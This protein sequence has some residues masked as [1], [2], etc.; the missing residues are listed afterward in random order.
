ME[1]DRIMDII[2]A[3][4]TRKSIRGYLPDP[5]PQEI[6]RAIL[7]TAL[8]SPSAV[9]NQPWE[10]TIVTGEV[11]DKIRHENVESLL[12]GVPAYDRTSRYAGVFKQRRV[13]LAKD[14]FA[15]MDI[16]RDDEVKRKEWSHRG[17]RFFDAPVAIIIS[18]DKSLDGSWSLFDI[19]AISQTICLAAMH[20]G[21]GTC[22]EDQGV[23]FHS[24]LRKHALIPENQ[25]IIIGI[26]LGYPDPDFPA[27][28]LSSRREPLD[29]V[30]TWLG[31]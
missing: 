4:K 9:N 30:S 27:N 14:I 20:Y 25:D 18:V 7:E 16:K 31:F 1:E 11:L 29:K 15:L 23:K 8:R 10:F 13:E 6:I 5:V 3:I 17:F 24:V 2:E 22:I 21:I 19:G 26:A 12:A 28:Q